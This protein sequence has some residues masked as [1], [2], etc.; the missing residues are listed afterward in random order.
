MRWF[1]LVFEG[2]SILVLLFM[3]IAGYPGLAMLWFL[4]SCVAISIIRIS[5]E[6]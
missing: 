1:M 4:W 3:L 5:N 6:L 2:L